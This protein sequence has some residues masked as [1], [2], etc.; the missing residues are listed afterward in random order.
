MAR[1]Q[2]GTKPLKSVRTAFKII[3]HLKENG[4]GSV[5]EVSQQFGFPKSTVHTH[6]STLNQLGYLA[7][8]N[9]TYRLSFRLVHLGRSIEES[10]DLRQIVAPV[11][12]NIAEETGERV[13]FAVEENGLATNIAITE[14]EKSIQH[15]FLPGGQ[16]RMH[17]TASGKAILAFLP[18]EKVDEIVRR[19][20]MPPQAPNTITEREELNASLESIR[21]DGIAY[22][23]EES[24]KG[25]FEIGKPILSDDE[26]PHGALEIAG[27]IK[28]L[29]DEEYCRELVDTVEKA[30]NEIEVNLLL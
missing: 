30:A 28:R 13:Y 25:M 12:E 10:H 22:A 21:E 2:N 5:K 8:D 27:P 11:V 6:L 1:H 29:D 15:Q 20:G 9:G 18:P 24:F 4:S 19:W 23:R 14:G 17:T 16:T 3:E 7:N 26:R